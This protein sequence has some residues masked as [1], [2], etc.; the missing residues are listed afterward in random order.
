MI[1][2]KDK[3]IAT[4]VLVFAGLAEY[5]HKLFDG[6]FHSNYI[7]PNTLDET[8][9]FWSDIIYHFFNESL[10]MIFVVL[11]C[12]KL[13]TNK[14]SKTLMALVFGWFLVEWVE[15]TLQMAKIIDIRTS[16]SNVSWIQLFT[17]LAGAAFVYL[18]GNKKSI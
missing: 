4:L 1:Y 6:I 10:T 5:F 15:I 3:S 18:F 16:T 7:N 9:I 13:W 8:K 2:L 14:A 12:A 11:A 17:A